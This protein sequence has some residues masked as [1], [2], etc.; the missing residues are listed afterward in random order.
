MRVERRAHAVG[1]GCDDELVV[2]QRVGAAIGPVG[3]ADRE[4][5]VLRLGEGGSVRARLRQDSID[6]VGGG[7]RVGHAEQDHERR[8]LRHG[9]R[10]GRDLHGVERE[11]GERHRHVAVE[12]RRHVGCP[13]DPGALGGQHLVDLLG[14][15]RVQRPI[16]VDALDRR[17]VSQDVTEGLVLGLGRLE[18]HLEVERGVGRNV[19]G[20]GADSGGAGR[21]QEAAGG[22]PDPDGEDANEADD[23]DPPR[24]DSGGG[25]DG[26]GHG[27]VTPLEIRRSVAGRGASVPRDGKSRV[28]PDRVRP[29]PHPR[30]RRRSAARDRPG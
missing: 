11:V 13:A 29:D 27:A 19:G 17:K 6:G 12:P 1:V 2:G 24:G 21:Q 18:A 10:V 28:C 4:A 5:E 14:H 3:A 8:H 9:H 30:R 15:L 20:A 23:G 26:G 22:D 7:G 16:E 25:T